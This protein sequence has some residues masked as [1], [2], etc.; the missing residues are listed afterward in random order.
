MGDGS[1]SL[2]INA[3]L[4][5]TLNQMKKVDLMYS[6]TDKA[7][8][9]ALMQEAAASGYTEGLAGETS[10]ELC[11]T[12]SEEELHIIEEQRQSGFNRGVDVKRMLAREKD[13]SDRE[14]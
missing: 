12:L 1:S 11:E 3:L 13:N 7:I 4:V 14:R 6:D 5:L 9:H 8:I 10:Y 2:E